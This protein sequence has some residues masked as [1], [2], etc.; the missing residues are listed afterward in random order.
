MHLQ[1]STE[2]KL[3]VEK[4]IPDH[5]FSLSTKLKSSDKEEIAIMGN[6]PLFALLSTQRYMH[7]KT[8]TYTIMCNNNPVGMFGVLP[9]KQ[10]HKYGAVW[11]LSSELEKKQW[12]YFSKRSKK[13]LEY[14]LSDYKYVFNLIPKHNKR[15]IKWLKWLGFKF[16]KE[17]LVV[18]G[19]QMLYFYRHIHGVY[20]KIQ[21]LL[22]DI[23]PVWATESKL[24]RTTVD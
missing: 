3:Y 1:G 13:W 8:Q 10:N 18:N 11:F 12:I 23:G 17:E 19:V 22:D 15:T 14:L 9:T 24:E 16:K 20:K 4:T 2:S 6:D 21:P 5:C 7:R